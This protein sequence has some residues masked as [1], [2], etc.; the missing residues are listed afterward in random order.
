MTDFGFGRQP[1]QQRF[2]NYNDRVTGPEDADGSRLVQGEVTANIPFA[3]NLAASRKGGES[4]GMRRLGFV[5]DPSSI[6][7]YEGQ[8]LIK[9]IRSRVGPNRGRNRNDPVF[10][11]FTSFRGLPIY[12]DDEQDLIRWE[13]TWVVA[14]ICKANVEMN[15]PIGTNE[16]AATQAGGLTIKTNNTE[17]ILAGSFVKATIPSPNDAERA[18]MRERAVGANVII[19]DCAISVVPEKPEDGIHFLGKLMH[20]FVSKFVVNRA[21]GRRERFL[22]DMTQRYNQPGGPPLTSAELFH[23][24]EYIEGSSIDFANYIL[25]AV[26]LGLVT[27]NLPTGSAGLNLLSASLQL[28]TPSSIDSQGA[29]RQVL[30]PG[31]FT[32]RTMPVGAV[33]D[34]VQN[35][36]GEQMLALYNLLGLNNALNQTVTA[37]DSLRELIMLTR[38]RGL[39]PMHKEFDS[40]RNTMSIANVGSRRSGSNLNTFEQTVDQMQVN[41]A[42]EGYMSFHVCFAAQALRR[43]ARATMT[44]RP[45]GECDVVM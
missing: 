19:D 15:E 6:N 13:H 26:R 34:A 17:P 37:S 24:T 30:G 11:A 43:F 25:L 20:A 41:R 9:Q 14:G 40:L 8:V 27:L 23:Y 29:P 31:N 2:Y 38:V 18:A 28:I 44:S 16:V 36:R 39:L 1:R 22:H 12:V 33:A 5:S 42:R 21:A 10:N 32:S 35:E 45:S 7:F 3:V 4:T